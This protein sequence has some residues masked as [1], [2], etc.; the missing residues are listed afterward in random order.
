MVTNRICTRL[1][2]DVHAAEVIYE[3]AVQSFLQGNAS[4]H[5]EIQFT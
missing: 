5:I 3:I 4:A 1:W 2:R